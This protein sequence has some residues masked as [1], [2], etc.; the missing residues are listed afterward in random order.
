MML[1]YPFSLMLSTG[2]GRQCGKEALPNGSHEDQHADADVGE[3][4]PTQHVDELG[5]G[6][7]SLSCQ[8]ELVN[9]C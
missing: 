9:V 2:Q 8:V 4:D 7:G 5:H 6:S 3:G 1:A